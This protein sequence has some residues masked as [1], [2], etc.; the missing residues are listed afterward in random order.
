[1]SRCRQAEWRPPHELAPALGESALD[2][3]GDSRELRTGGGGWRATLCWSA[4]AWSRR[5]SESCARTVRE[6]FAKRLGPARCRVLRR[7]RRVRRKN[8]ENPCA[9]WDGLPPDHG[10]VSGFRLF[11]L[12]GSGVCGHDGSAIW[13]PEPTA[14]NRLHSGHAD[15]TELVF[16]VRK[17]ANVTTLTINANDVRVPRHAR[18][19]VERHDPVEVMK[20]DALQYVLVHPDDF[21]LV[22]PMIERYRSGRPVPFDRLL[23]ADDLAFMADDAERDADL[24]HGTLEAWS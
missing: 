17:G 3:A 10:N 4:S 9:A 14:Q 2:I 24:A 11:R 7:T 19:A 15:R 8:L 20:H 1:M 5:G 6:M 21:E 16:S 18:E 12:R 22:R 23:D 13:L